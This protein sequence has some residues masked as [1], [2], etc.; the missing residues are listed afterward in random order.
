MM[1]AAGATFLSYLFLATLTL[2]VSGRLY[3]VDYEYFR[4]A[5]MFITALLI[6]A[7]SRLLVFES[8]LVSIGARTALVLAFPLVL[9]VFRF[10][11]QRE[12]RKI[13]EFVRWSV[14][15]IRRI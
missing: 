12:R 13:G 15:R 3:R 2:F 5:K 10:Y 8:L 6:F 9:V 11:D 7:V 14:A 1:G 4:L